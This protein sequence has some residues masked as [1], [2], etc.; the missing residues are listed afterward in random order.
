MNVKIEKHIGAVACSR[1][2]ETFWN[3]GLW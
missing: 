2:L 3:N 1:T